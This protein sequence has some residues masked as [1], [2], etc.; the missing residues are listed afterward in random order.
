MTTYSERLLK[1]EIDAVNAGMGYIKPVHL[2]YLMV[3][4]LNDLFVL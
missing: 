3:I 4:D 2:F 1:I